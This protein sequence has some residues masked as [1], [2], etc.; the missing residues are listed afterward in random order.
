MIFLGLQFMPVPELTTINLLAPLLVT[1]LAAWLLH[2]HVSRLRWSL[3]AGGM[4]GALIVIRPGSGVFGLAVLL[5]LAGAF[6]YAAFQ[7]L[8]SRLSAL[9]PATTTHFWT[10]L[11]GTVLVTPLLLW[12]AP[13]RPPAPGTGRCSRWWLPWA[14]AG[15]CC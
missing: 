1:L 6:T 3:V 11:V 7:V 2:E 5:P 15:I 9:D 14:P 13:S 4:V 12:Q 10:G 8:T